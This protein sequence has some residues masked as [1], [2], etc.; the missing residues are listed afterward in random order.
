MWIGPNT[1][2]LLIATT[3]PTSAAFAVPVRNVPALLASDRLR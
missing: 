1:H 3:F 2:T